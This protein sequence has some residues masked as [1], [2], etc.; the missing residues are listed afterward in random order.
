MGQSLQKLGSRL[1]PELDRSR[2]QPAQHR[3]A[4]KEAFQS[5]VEQVADELSV[6][7]VGGVGFRVQLQQAEQRPAEG[8]DL[9]EF[10]IQRFGAES[11][12]ACKQRAF[13]RTIGRFRDQR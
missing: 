3:I 5:I 4:S 12:Q 2:H 7:A 6:A 13:E 8:T 1:D 10:M 11:G 9:R